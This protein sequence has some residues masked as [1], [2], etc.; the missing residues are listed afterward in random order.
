MP[1]SNTY[2]TTIRGLVQGVGFRPFIYRLAHDFQLKGWVNNTNENVQV[3]LNADPETLDEF[4]D[5][6]RH[7]AP[8]AAQIDSIVTRQ[9]AAEEFKDFRILDSESVSEAVTRVSPDIAVCEACLDDM[10]QQSTRIDYPF[11]NC[12]N[13]GPRFTII[14][15]L[16]YDRA[17]TTMQAFEM[18]DSCRKEYEDVLDRRF[19]AQPTACRECGPAY[20]LRESRGV[21]HTETKG[22]QDIAASTAGL[23]DGGKIVSVKGLGGF[24]MACDARNEETVSRLRASK[25]REGKPFAVMFRDADTV[26]EF[27]LLTP[28]E[29]AELISWRRPILI[30]RNQPDPGD[31]G[32]SRDSSRLAA[33]VSNG[34]PTTGVMLPYMPFH[35]LLFEKLKTPVIVLTSGNLSEVPIIIDNKL[36][37]RVLGPVS[38]AVLLYNREIH[39]RCDDSVAQVVNSQ[40]R[41]LRRSR[42]FVPHP[43]IIPLEAEGIFAA[44]AEL[45]NCFAMGKDRQAILSQH[46]GDLKNYETYEFYRETYGRF[47]KLF[48]LDPVL[49][50]HDLHP[51]Y[52]STAFARDLELPLVPVQ[53]H[54][55]HIASVLA[56]H[57]L[58]EK[59]IGVS[60]DGTGLGDDGR[61]WGS[62][63]LV[64]DLESYLR[65][66][67][68]E[69]MPMP[70][71]D[72]V[73]D[74]PWRMAVSFLYAVYGRKFL[75]LDLPFLKSLDPDM[76]DGVVRALEKKLHC[77]LSSGAGRLFDA[78]SAL[79]NICTFSSFHA[80]APMRLES[81]IRP[82]KSS[83]PYTRLESAAH[84][85]ESS[86]RSARPEG[87]P[88][89][90]KK[91]N[92]GTQNIC[93]GP[94]IEAMVGDLQKG[95]D[96]G[97][98]S[99]RFHNTV[100]RIITETVER[101][102]RESGL[103]KLVLSGGTFQ[104]R[105]LSERVENDLRRK[106]FEVLVPLQLPT[107]DGGIAL[108][109]LAVAAKHRSL[110]LI[111]G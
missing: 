41:L 60:F 49:A 79:L 103:K 106:G 14:R 100:A 5:H 69:Y 111:G 13:C 57:R 95:V 19:H 97:L 39:N 78:V 104:N 101:I 99:A 50:A 30:L 74:E 29:E 46:I 15:D 38:D 34:F 43:V 22:T 82:D 92:S 70:G 44:G 3:A 20:S 18:C 75:A 32:V 93:M 87:G 53:H 54:H 88:S 17:R 35:Y 42:G 37:E 109:Q 67:H 1:G 96:R 108:G 89:G 58:D 105:V 90:G 102:S 16:P 64:C 40:T 11:L 9:I 68:L 65:M 10:K 63:F 27:C 51:D 12:T 86:T 33:S 61:I 28:E 80:E 66:A 85:D 55:A 21:R 52:L 47:K 76:L 25:N 73:T 4:I 107:N 81:A 45:V 48:R 91:N 36:A 94:A 6:L 31:T 110:G 98:I 84:R 26:R 2:L 77:P 71:G 24:F 62:E 8:P 59:V 23:I 83:Y 7:L 72:K 56:E